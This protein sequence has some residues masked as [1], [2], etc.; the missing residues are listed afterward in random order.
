MGGSSLLLL[1]N[2][3]EDEITPDII[4]SDNGIACIINDEKSYVTS[5]FIEDA[6]LPAI[7]VCYLINNNRLGY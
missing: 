6:F 4:T 1:F 5:R 7:T 3:E 2:Q